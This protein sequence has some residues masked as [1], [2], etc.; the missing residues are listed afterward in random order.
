M[1]ENYFLW[2]WLEAER[3]GPPLPFEDC[4]LASAPWN[5]RASFPLTP[6]LWVA[7]LLLH[8]CY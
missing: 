6:G 4:A 7:V 3:G 1:A 2:P 8:I 5:R